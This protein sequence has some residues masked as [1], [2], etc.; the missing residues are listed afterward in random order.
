MVLEQLAHAANASVAEVVDVIHLTDAVFKT[1]VVAD[2]CDDIVDGDV[3]GNKHIATAR[4]RSDSLFYRQALSKNFFKCGKIDRFVDTDGF[5]LEID[6]GI[7]RIDETEV[8]LDIDGVITDNLDLLVGVIVVKNVNDVDAAV[9]NDVSLFLGKHF[10]CGTDNDVLGTLRSFYGSDYVLCQSIINPV[11]AVV[12]VRRDAVCQ[13][14]FFIEFITPHAC[15]VVTFT[16]KQQI[17]YLFINRLVGGNFARTETFVKFQL[18]ATLVF[19]FVLVAGV[20]NGN[21]VKEQVFDLFVR[22]N[23]DGSQQYRRR[24]FTVAVD[25]NV[26]YIVVGVMNEFQ[27][28]AAVGNNGGIVLYFSALVHL[29]RRIHA[30]RTHQLTY[31]YALRTVNDKTARIGHQRKVTH[32]DFV[33]RNFAGVLSHET[34]LEFQRSGVSCV[35]QSALVFRILAFRINGVIEKLQLETP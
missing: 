18:A 25:V 3:T 2:G 16:V 17:F 1:E 23:A 12:S 19:A 29:C 35:A 21:V 6:V 26:Q 7:T 24:E 32:I 27:P 31:Y 22:R 14:E 13:T 5:R 15:K 28:G 34:D 11:G 30:G 10:A 9:L 4:Y 8:V 20:A 33:F